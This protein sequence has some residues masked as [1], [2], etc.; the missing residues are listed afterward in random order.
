MHKDLSS[1]SSNKKNERKES[2][3]GKRQRRWKDR[4]DRRGEKAGVT[5]DMKNY[6]L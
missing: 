1:S 6:N 5:K 2:G 4:E 3:V